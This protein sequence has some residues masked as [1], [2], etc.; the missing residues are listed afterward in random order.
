MKTSALPH[1]HPRPL[2]YTNGPE[3]SELRDRN[4]FQTIAEIVNEDDGSID[5]RVRRSS[6]LMGQVAA[7]VWEDRDYA[8]FHLTSSCC[9]EQRKKERKNQVGMRPS[10][11]RNQQKP[12][13]HTKCIRIRSPNSSPSKPHFR[14]DLRTE[15]FSATSLS[16]PFPKTHKWPRDFR[17]AGPES[18]SH[19]TTKKPGASRPPSPPTEEFFEQLQKQEFFDQNKFTCFRQDLRR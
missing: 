8:M 19:A 7:S 12:R 10:R 6:D 11:Q 2:R 13:N 4:H 9:F 17:I 3:I 14:R 5:R 16:C 15:G 1:Y 18:F